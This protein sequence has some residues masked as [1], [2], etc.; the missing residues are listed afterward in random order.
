[1]HDYEGFGPDPLRRWVTDRPN[2]D[3]QLAKMQLFAMQLV[4]SHDMRRAWPEFEKVGL[5]SMHLRAL[6]ENAAKNA[7]REAVREPRA[8]ETK[9]LDKV[10]T[11]IRRLKRAI[12]ESPLP[13]N[14]GIDVKIRSKRISPVMIIAGW[15]DMSPDVGWSAHPVS[16]TDTLDFYLEMLQQHRASEPARAVQRSAK[17]LEVNAFVVNLGWLICKEFGSYLPGSIA[18]VTNAIY[19]P[20]DPL[21]KEA[22]RDILKRSPEP[23]L[24]FKQVGA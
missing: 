19:D 4:D 8:I 17:H 21:N 11:L 5:G 15:H 24:R 20:P 3:R 12:Q 2:P 14:S 9:K 10:D 22:V 18:R 16:L 1:M 23:F 6:I 7:T 13:R